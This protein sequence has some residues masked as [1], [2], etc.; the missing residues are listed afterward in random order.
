[1][2][3]SKRRAKTNDKLNAVNQEI[4]SLSSIGFDYQIIWSKQFIRKIGSE[5]I[6][7]YMQLNHLDTNLNY[8]M[9]TIFETVYNNSLNRIESSF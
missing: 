2:K 7:T 9:L 8:R 3:Q 4:E 5:Y 6:H 1:M